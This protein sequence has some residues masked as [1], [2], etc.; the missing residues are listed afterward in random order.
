MTTKPTCLI[1]DDEPNISEF[2]AV[3]L[4]KMGIKV[5]CSET[6]ADAKHLIALRH[7]DLC[8]TDM[9]L[10][11]GNGLDLV[12]HIGFQHAGLPIA[13]MTAYANSDN[14]VSALKAGAFD[15]LSKPI[16]I[17]QLQSLVR[18]AL[19][20]GQN[21]EQRNAKVSLLGNSQAMAQVRLTLEK[22]SLN[23][24][25]LLITGELG[26]GKESAA[27]LVHINSSRREQAF[28]KVNCAALNIENAEKDFF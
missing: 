26:T 17:Q 12:K 10:P 21:N 23:Q 14:A 4:E 27:R 20:Y 1:V 18:A 8:L 22:M 5:D 3:N 19:K 13:I 7:Y 6:V 16:E 15:Y 2:I 9:R 11:D 25:P 24:A 28:I